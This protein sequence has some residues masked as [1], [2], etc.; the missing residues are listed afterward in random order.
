MKNRREENAMLLSCSNVTYSED[1]NNMKQVNQA[2]LQSHTHNKS[3]FF[4][5]TAKK[6]KTAPDQKMN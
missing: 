2:K 5:I 4:I 3:R 6:K 1:D